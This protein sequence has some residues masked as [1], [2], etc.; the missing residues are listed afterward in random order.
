MDYWKILCKK[1]ILY[2][3]LF[4]LTLGCGIDSGKLIVGALICHLLICR[5]KGIPYLGTLRKHVKVRQTILFIAFSLICA[6]VTIPFNHGQGMLLLKYVERIIPL[7]LV[8]FLV[9]PEEESFK[10]LWI[11]ILVSLTWYIGD[12][13]FHF[14]WQSG[15]LSGSFGSPNGLASTML[16]LIPIGLFGII[17]YRCECSKLV[18]TAVIL[19]L[20][21]SISILVCTGSRNAY[22]SFAVIWCILLYTVYRHRDW[23]LV[24]VLA[25]FVVLVC[26]AAAIAVP[27]LIGQR[28][29]QNVQRDG[30]VYL[31]QTAVQII[32]EKPLIGI[33]MGNW[34]QVYHERFEAD[35]PN[36]EVNMQSPHNIYLQVW[37]ETGIIGLIGFLSLIGF[38]LKT[39]FMSLKHFYYYQPHGLS[40]LNG[41]FMP[42]FSIFLFGLF[43][44]DFFSRHMMH[45][46]WFYWGLCLH[47]I[48]YYTKEY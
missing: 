38:Q 1:W 48:Q 32:K 2:V 43:D 18:I 16:T 12:T 39:L 37:N 20:A 9:R 41:L 35:N 40:W 44:Y 24:K 28:M 4:L 5:K 29:H 42:I 27:G 31:M 8:I 46:Y 21:A 3:P 13:C 47:A 45:L 30:R 33:G 26:L 36:H 23:L 14:T 22:F 25:G 10:V 19:L 7:V 34:G 15:R 11:G 6:A 17:R